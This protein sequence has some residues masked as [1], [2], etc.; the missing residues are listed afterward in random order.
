LLLEVFVIEGYRQ[1]SENKMK[2]ILF[3]LNL[4]LASA[5]LLQGPAGV[6]KKLVTASAPAPLRIKVAKSSS[7]SAPSAVISALHDEAAA[8]LSSGMA[9]VLREVQVSRSSFLKVD[10]NLGSNLK[11]ALFDTQGL[12]SPPSMSLSVVEKENTHAAAARA[13]TAALASKG[14]YVQ[15]NAIAQLLAMRAD[16]AQ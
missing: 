14:R 3:V 10:P 5:T 11:N 13:R 9:S 16:A 4:G 7:V 6:L 8:T 15:E 2:V 12:R 1:V